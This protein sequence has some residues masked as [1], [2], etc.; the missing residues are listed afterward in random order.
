MHVAV[1]VGVGVTTPDG[2]LP[3]PFTPKAVLFCDVGNFGL[4]AEERATTPHKKRSAAALLR[5]M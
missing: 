1:G 3:C 4:I 2:T 5:T